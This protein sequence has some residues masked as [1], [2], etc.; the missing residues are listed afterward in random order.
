[1]TL[2]I[3]EKT[4]AGDKRLEEAILRFES[5][6]DFPKVQTWMRKAVKAFEKRAPPKSRVHGSKARLKLVILILNLK[7]V[8]YLPMV[9]DMATLKDFIVILRGWEFEAWHYY[10][11]SS[12]SAL[13]PTNVG[14]ENDS[15]PIHEN[16]ENWITAVYEQLL[17][18]PKEETASPQDSES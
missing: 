16:I 12:S 6:R 18:P 8:A 7:A 5:H 4:T 14:S 11:G 1:V 2:E 10:L 13:L 9:S 3:S 15:S 17:E